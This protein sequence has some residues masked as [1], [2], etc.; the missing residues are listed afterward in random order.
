MKK[1]PIVTLEDVM[2][3]L[4]RDLRIVKGEAFREQ[5][6]P[7][8]VDA[9]QLSEQWGLNVSSVRRIA[10]QLES[11]GKWQWIRVRDPRS[12]Q[13]LNVLRR[14]QNGKKSD[15]TSGDKRKRK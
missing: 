15:T 2:S 8:D 4:E 3:E 5:R 12:P 14:V 10:R 7:G 6:L 1:E 13:G 9:I 11:T